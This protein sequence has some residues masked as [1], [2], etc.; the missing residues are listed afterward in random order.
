MEKTSLLG[1]LSLSLGPL[2]NKTLGLAAAMLLLALAAVT[3]VDV[4]GRYWFNAPL[5]GAF[6]LTEVLL[7]ALVFAG[8]PL[9]TER[10]EHVEVDLLDMLLPRGGN[11]ALQGFAGVVSALVL[12]AFAFSVFEQAMKL[13]RDG[14]VTNALAVPLSP[15]AY[16]AAVS[17]FLCALISLL[18]AVFD[19]PPIFGGA[20]A[21]SSDAPTN[22]SVK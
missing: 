19:P 13:A 14:S 1:G 21:K 5:A 11:R 20:T 15:L 4:M 3:C 10:R 12:F 9:T 6:E 7:C 17:C 22:E 16:F 8:L 18:R 2:L